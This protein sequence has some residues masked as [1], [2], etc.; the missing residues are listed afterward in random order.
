M[1]P[2]CFDSI[3]PRRSFAV[4]GSPVPY[5]PKRCFSMTPLPCPEEPPIRLSPQGR[6]AAY[7]VGT[8]IV[9]VAIGLGTFS[10]WLAFFAP[11]ALC[12][13]G[14]LL[15]GLFAEFSSNQGGW[16]G[17]KWGVAVYACQVP[18]VLV[19][20][21]PLGLIIFQL[22][23]AWVIP[24]GLGAL[25]GAIAAALIEASPVHPQQPAQP[26]QSGGGWQ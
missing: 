13:V 16:L 14:M 25:G 15:V 7:L 3:A 1:T 26:S 6:A 18:G 5:R 2:Q 8:V 9:G 11:I 23:V 24:F 19:D 10:S 20:K 21:G 12:F 22:L 17:F 4:G